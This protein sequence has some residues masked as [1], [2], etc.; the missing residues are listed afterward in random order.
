MIQA[1]RQLSANAGPIELW[2]IGFGP[3]ERRLRQ[4]AA[5]DSRIKF[6]GA[7]TEAE[8]VTEIEALLGFSGIAASAAGIAQVVFWIA[9]V[10]AVIGFFM[11][12]TRL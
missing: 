11:G 12:R 6:L 3:E 5:G 7:K 10:L 2:L 1:F 4:V 8:Y 9:L